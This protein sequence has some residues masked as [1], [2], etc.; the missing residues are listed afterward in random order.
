MEKLHLNLSGVTLDFYFNKFDTRTIE[1]FDVKFT[2]RIEKGN[3]FHFKTNKVITDNEWINEKIAPRIR[4]DNS[5]DIISTTQTRY[6][7]SQIVSGKSEKLSKSMLENLR[8]IDTFEMT[9]PEATLN[10]S[11]INFTP[12]KFHKNHFHYILNLC[13]IS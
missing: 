1:D 8:Q 3:T 4:E 5:T 2:T 6:T 10:G 7:F 9:L 13:W 12:I 11:T